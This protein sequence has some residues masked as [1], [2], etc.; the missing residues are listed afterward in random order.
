MFV[1]QKI[2]E[3]IVKVNKNACDKQG[4]WLKMPKV[5]RMPKWPKNLKLKKI[6]KKIYKWLKISS[7][8]KWKSEHKNQCDLKYLSECQNNQK[9]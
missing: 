9:C 4:Q 5:L 1:W 2:S 3:K 8:Q 6:R 7:K